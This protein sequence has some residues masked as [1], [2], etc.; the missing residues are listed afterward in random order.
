MASY[1]FCAD[2]EEINGFF[3][4]RLSAESRKRLADT[5]VKLKQA[6]LRVLKGYLMTVGITFIQLYVGLLILKTEYAFTLAGIIALV[7]ILP[8]IGVGTVLIP[9]GIF[10]L[11]AGAYYQGFGLLII[12]A[13]VS[14]V[15]EIIEPKIIGKSLGLHPLM[16][17]FSMYIGLELC[18]F[19]G[20]ISFPALVIVAKTLMFSK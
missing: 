14:V 11:V 2:Y 9:W 3:L 5:R 1:Y 10:K 17:L 7:D 12:F 18:G 6:A 4:S 20:M 15:R 13:V 8:V 19:L 16:T